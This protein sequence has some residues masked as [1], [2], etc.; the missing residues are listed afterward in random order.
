ML[1]LM[2]AGDLC[3]WAWLV[4]SPSFSAEATKT[5]I[6]SPPNSL[7]TKGKKEARSGSDVKFEQTGESST[8]VTLKGITVEPSVVCPRIQKD[9]DSLISQE[10]TSAIKATVSKLKETALSDP[11]DCSPLTGDQTVHSQPLGGVSRPLRE[12]ETGSDQGQICGDREDLSGSSEL[13]KD[14]EPCTFTSTTTAGDGVTNRNSKDLRSVES[15][16]NKSFEETD[17]SELSRDTE[18]LKQSSESIP[19]RETEHT[20]DNEASGG[21]NSEIDPSLLDF[22]HVMRHTHGKEHVTRWKSEFDPIKQGQEVL[23]KYIGAARGPLKNHGWNYSRAVELIVKLKRAEAA[24][25][26]K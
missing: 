26:A 12:I 16:F 6:T 24:I 8:E 4:S 13:L 20:A 17:N 1:A 7:G 5:T 15:C 9:N 21:R 2:Y 25:R 14:S 18:P 23:S 11:D 22:Y 19:T 3:Y 10:E